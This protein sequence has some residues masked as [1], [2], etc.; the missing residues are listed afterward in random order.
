MTIKFANNISTT[1]ALGAGIAA[2]SFDVVSTTGFPVLGVG[3]YFYGTLSN[4]LGAIEIVQVT[5]WTGVTVTC[6]RGAE[7]TPSAAWSTGDSFEIRIT[8]A[9]LTTVLNATEVVEEVQTATSGQTVFTLTTF[10]YVPGENTLSVYVDGVNQIVD[11]SYAETG[12]TTV[13]FISGLHLGALVKFTTL[14]TSGLTTSAAVVTYEPAGTGAVA[15]TVQSKLRESVSVLDFGAVGDGVTDD[16][17][18]FQACVNA[19]VGITAL[20]DSVVAGVFSVHVPAGTYLVSTIYL[21]NLVVLAGE[22]ATD[23]YGATQLI[24]VSNAPVL[25]LGRNVNEDS[26]VTVEISDIAIKGNLTGNNQIGI[27]AGLNGGYLSGPVLNNVKIG[28]MGASGIYL[29][30]SN[31][32]SMLLYSHWDKVVIQNCTDY[33]VYIRMAVFNLSSFTNCVFT[34]GKLGGFYVDYIGGGTTNFTEAISF[35]T[36]GIEGNGQLIGE[37]AYG[38]NTFGF[39][40]LMIG[41]QYTFDNCYIENNGLA[42][43]GSGCAVFVQEPH[44]VAFRNSYLAGFTTLLRMY[45]GG[46]ADLTGNYIAP[47]T[48]PLTSVLMFDTPPSVAAESYVN[49]GM[50]Q[51]WKQYVSNAE[52]QTSINSAITKII[53]YRNGRNNYLVNTPRA[54]NV[55]LRDWSDTAADTGAIGYNAVRRLTNNADGT[56][57]IGVNAVSSICVQNNYTLAFISDIYNSKTALFMICPTGVV[58]VSQVGTLFTVTKDTALSLNVYYDAGT[59]NYVLQ[60]KTALGLSYLAVRFVGCEA[61]LSIDNYSTYEAK[62]LPTDS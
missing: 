11:L 39:K 34:Y 58:L 8:A 28:G 60:N 9:G 55:V 59:G 38:S 16:T 52:L 47:L 33:C 15:T 14:R 19:S 5:G 36:C 26:A 42:V 32:S 31:L 53:G 49:I 30:S 45:K 3:D 18:A 54:K 17:A 24:T 25:V 48:G 50:N 37:P 10:M 6:T 12:T 40:S 22:C 61:M 27:R 7:G 13:T 23:V 46:Y 21:P 51:W 29:A 56:T 44:M 4:T 2:T 41:C 1:L 20:T 43:D 57:L 62:F 35:D